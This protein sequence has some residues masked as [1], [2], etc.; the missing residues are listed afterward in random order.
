MFVA[1]PGGTVGTVESELL[2][3]SR[4]EQFEETELHVAGVGDLNGR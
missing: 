2:L 4:V 1:K 3:C